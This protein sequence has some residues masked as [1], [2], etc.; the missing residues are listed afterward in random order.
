MANKVKNIKEAMPN[1]NRFLEKTISKSQRCQRNWDLTKTIPIED[2][3]TM[4]TSVTQCSSKQNRVF[5][6]VKFVTNRDVIHK[7][8]QETGGAGYQHP[9]KSDWKT[10]EE[11]GFKNREEATRADYDPHPQDRNLWAKRTYDRSDWS[12]NPQILANLMVAFVRDRD[13]SEGYRTLEERQ[14]G[15]FFSKE[16]EHAYVSADEQVAL[17]IGAGYL[18]LT[19]NM[20][21]YATGCCQCGDM[22]KISEYLGE[23]EPTLLLMGVGYP[24]EGK[25]RLVH[26]LSNKRFP[27]FNKN[28]LVDDVA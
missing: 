2:I 5:Y 6:K 1:A 19:A 25:S 11:H 26:H 10:L 21:G 16:K 13:P 7:I 22:E 24:G 18:T 9:E 12:T 14:H 27:S 15:R 8:Y 28:V 20:L 4:K 3:K 17:G 23:D